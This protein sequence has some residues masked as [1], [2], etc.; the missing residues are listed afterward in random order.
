LSIQLRTKIASAVATGDGLSVTFAGNNNPETF[1]WFWLYD[2]SQD[3]SRY[4][5]ETKQ[6]TVDTFKIDI[7]IAGINV[8]LVD[9]H[10]VVIKWNDGSA[11]GSYSVE[12]LAS[13]VGIDT[14]QTKQQLW[15]AG[16][17]PNLNPTVEFETVVSTD[18]GLR[19]W[20]DAV[21]TFG[22]GTVQN[23]PPDEASVERLARRIGYPRETIFGGLW[24]L[25]SELEDHSDT[26][27]SQTFLEPHSDGTYSH[28]APGLQMFCCIDRTGTGGE[29]TLVDGFAVAEQ[30]R[31]QDPKAFATLTT[32]IVPG[33]YIEAG[34]HLRAERPAIRLDEHAN[35]AQ[36]SF[37]NYDRAPMKLPNTEMTEFYR[38]YGEL[39]RRINDRNN[40][41][42]I[43][44]NSG[45]VLLFDNWRLLHGR[46]EYTGKRLFIGCYHN[47]EDFESRRRVLGSG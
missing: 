10:Q 12:L 14:D 33:H 38:A 25:S 27:Y 37:N 44:L 36:I 43:R 3:P 28:D 1:S 4:N 30:I 16:S 41:L 21:A 6:R 23:M 11:P 32:T 15:F 13:A 18:D 22:F 29:S 9:G 42:K 40:W 45:D 19:D 20:L 7:S 46:M 47:R 35:V 24:K 31:R 5:T 8:E 17:L 39:H 26:A 2:H 34:V